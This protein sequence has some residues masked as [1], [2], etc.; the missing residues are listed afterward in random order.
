MRISAF[1]YGQVVVAATS[2]TLFVGL[3]SQFG[4]GQTTDGEKLVRLQQRLDALG[5][6]GGGTLQLPPGQMLLATG[7]SEWTSDY[8]SSDGNNPFTVGLRI[9]S[10]VRIVGAGMQK[11]I[12]RYIRLA[13]DPVCSLFANVDRVNG[14]SDISLSDLS[15]ETE[16]E[17]GAAGTA[18]SSFSAPIYMNRV[19]GFRLEHV[20]IEGNT[21]RQINLM[22]VDGAS[23]Q[24][25]RLAVNST[26][27][28]YGDSSIGVN[29]STAILPPTPLVRIENN[30]FTEIG[31]YPT[32]SIIVAT[33]TDI[34]IA[35][36]LFDL[37]TFR[38]G[39]VG[40]NAIEVGPN[41]GAEAPARI[42]VR[43]NTI[44]G[45]EVW[46]F[47]ASDTRI[48]G[49][50]IVDGGIGVTAADRTTTTS[51]SNVTITHNVVQS[52]SI[53]AQAVTSGTL[54]NLQ[55][56]D[57]QVSDGWIQVQ[58]NLAGAEILRNSIR[59][60]PGDGI[61]CYGCT[62]IAGNRVE[63]VG[64]SDPWDGASIAINV[65]SLGAEFWVE[66]A[67]HNTVVD[68]QADYNAGQIC[69][70]SE[71]DANECVSGKARFVRLAGGSWDPAW[72]NRTLYLN[73]AQLLIRRFVSAVELELEKPAAIPLG[74]AYQMFH[75]TAVAFQLYSNIDSF[76]FNA[77]S[78]MQGW[79][80][81]AIVQQNAAGVITVGSWGD[82][83]FS[84]YSCSNCSFL[85]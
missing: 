81:A 25:N 44:L 30:V 80:Q 50:R 35:N 85:Y 45:G 77:G 5:K 21:D 23:I 22:D 41:V 70:V 17:T 3:A 7:C 76:S 18:N 47:W 24:R 68:G 33:A 13:G 58:G 59:N 49:N 16:D 39:I 52:G 43:A 36:N 38:P 48:T 74:S 4:L 72:T 34:L 37:E 26:G 60:S 79:R 51:L 84:P 61:D 46:P 71:E 8:Q 28:G 29:R 40:G 82:N 54:T 1:F 63:N 20:H 2:I 27:Y 11:T 56:A 62:V 14:N 78:A 83:V 64:Q 42:V 53:Q 73:G 67:D 19:S 66:R 69:G 75:T 12:F 15:I 9:P 65:G 10:H 57:N 6:S 32:F 31:S 55:I